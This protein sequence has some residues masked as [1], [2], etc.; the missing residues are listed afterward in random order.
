MQSTWVAKTSLSYWAW[1]RCRVSWVDEAHSTYQRPLRWNRRE[2]A[3]T[4]HLS[5]Q[6]T[7]RSL[8]AKLLHGMWMSRSTVDQ[9]GLADFR[10]VMSPV[11]LSLLPL[12]WKVAGTLWECCHQDVSGMWAGSEIDSKSLTLWV[13]H[14]LQ[15]LTHSNSTST[16]SPELVVLSHQKD[17]RYLL[18]P[19]W[20]RSWLG[21]HRNTETGQTQHFE[22]VENH[23][24]GPHWYPLPW[25]SCIP[26]SPSSVRGVDFYRS[27]W[28]S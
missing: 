6:R 9:V 27:S 3:R 15:R 28:V 23:L 2:N 24:K 13:R 22:R 20:R 12:W 10:H 4:Y 14:P 21:L 5:C 17:P 26:H 18:V 11:P 7:W 1:Q 19:H 25:K 8:W 16:S